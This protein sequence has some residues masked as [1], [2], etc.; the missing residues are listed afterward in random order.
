MS[1]CVTTF[2]LFSVKVEHLVETCVFPKIYKHR[3]EYCTLP[4]TQGLER[5]MAVCGHDYLYLDIHKICVNS[6]HSFF[7]CYSYMKEPNFSK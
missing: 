4:W 2:T 7:F 3:H 6:T 1:D 5:Q